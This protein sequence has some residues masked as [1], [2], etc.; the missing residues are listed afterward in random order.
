MKRVPVHKNR[1]TG[2][3]LK[4]EKNR[5]ERNGVKRPSIG[6]KCRAVWDAM[7]TLVANGETPSVKLMR[8]IAEIAGWNVNNTVAELYTWRRFHGMPGRSAA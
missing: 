7:D 6:G 8:A 5:E 1:H 2:N 3:G 4:I